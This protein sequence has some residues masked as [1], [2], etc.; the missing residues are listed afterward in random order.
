MLVHIDDIL[1]FGTRKTSLE[2]LIPALQEKYT[3]FIC[4]H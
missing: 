3:V 2:E 4:F 1:V